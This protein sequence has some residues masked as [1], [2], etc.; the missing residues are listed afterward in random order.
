M[1]TLE[2]AAAWQRKVQEIVMANSEASYSRNFSYG[3][4]CGA[5]IQDAT[6]FPSGIGRASSFDAGLEEKIAE[7][8]SRQEAACGITMY[9][10]RF[11]DI[12]R[13]F[14][15]GEAGKPMVRIRCWLP[16][17]E[18][19]IQEASKGRNCRKK[20]REC[21]KAFSGFS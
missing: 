19:L 2:E 3:G 12:S 6:S 18:R 5:F 10:R 17:W 15:H 16:L 21:G 14:P 1:E 11:L 13:E 9:W 8:V 4:L 7:I 20:D